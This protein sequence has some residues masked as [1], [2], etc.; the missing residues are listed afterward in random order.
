VTYA[1]MTKGEAQR[2]I[3]T[4]YEVVRITPGAALRVFPIPQVGLS[5]KYIQPDRL[6]NF[7]NF[8]DYRDKKQKFLVAN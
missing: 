6:I 1:A 8:T 4:F 3:R 7:G 2:S 5:V